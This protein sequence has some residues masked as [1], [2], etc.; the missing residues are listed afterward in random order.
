MDGFVVLCSDCQYS[1]HRWHSRPKKQ[2]T[3]VP[4]IRPIADSPIE[5]VRYGYADDDRVAGTVADLWRSMPR[6]HRRRLLEYLRSDDR[7]ERAKYSPVAPGALRIETLPRWP[8]WGHGVMG[9]NLERGHIIRLWTTAVQ[10][11]SQPALTAL[12]GHELAHTY[13]DAVGSKLILDYET[14]T[15]EAEAEA[16][17]IASSWGCDIRLLRVPVPARKSP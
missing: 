10:R 13:Q 14:H 3:G 6:A 2:W 9:L 12:V 1:V 15:V 11:M 5:V 4:A 16:N 8:N 17:E 7:C